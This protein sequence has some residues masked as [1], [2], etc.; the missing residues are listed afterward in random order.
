MYTF[1]PESCN[2]FALKPRI[3]AFKK[4]KSCISENLLQTW[5][6]WRNCRPLRWDA[7]G[8]FLASHTKST[9]D[10]VRDRIRQAI[11]PYDDIFTMVKKPKWKLFGHVASLQ[12]LQRQFYKEQC[13]EGEEGANK[14]SVG[15]ITSLS[16]QRWSFVM[17]KERLAEN[18][19]QWRERV[20]KSFLNHRP[21]S[22]KSSSL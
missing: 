22:V 10:A 12:G 14:R 17:P 3:P 4:G 7:L 8:N 15:R 11:G 6:C 13:K 2:H 21:L 20:A 19:I 18:K 9:N 5:T 16:R 1:N